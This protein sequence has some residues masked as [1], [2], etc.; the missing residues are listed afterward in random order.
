MQNIERE[1]EKKIDDIAEITLLESGSNTNNGAWVILVSVQ[2]SIISICNGKQLF[3]G[4]CWCFMKRRLYL[5]VVDEVECNLFDLGGG[6]PFFNTILIYYRSKFFAILKLSMIR[7]KST[8]SFLHTHTN[9][10]Y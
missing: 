1:R 2:E 9:E 4:K 5:F 7:W 8:I 3:R 6:Y 10:A